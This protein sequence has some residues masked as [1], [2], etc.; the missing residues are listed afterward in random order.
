[1]NVQRRIIT[2]A[3]ENNKIELL[4]PAGSMESLIAAINAG[5][6]AVYAG[7][8]KFGARAFAENFDE[9]TMIKAIKMVHAA[10]KKLYLTV[11]TLLKQSE[12]E[13][14]LASYIRPYYEAGLDA[15]LVQD[16]GVLKFL[17][18]VFP[19]L[20][21]HASTQMSINM[22]EAVS[23]MP[24]TRIVPSRELSLDEI[25][26]LRKST[27]KEI[28]CFAHGALCYSYSGR[29]MFSSL[30]GGRSGNRGMCAGSCRLRYEMVDNG[31]SIADGYL[32]SLK[33]MST[34]SLLPELM[35]AGINS[36]KLEGRMKGPSYAGGVAR[37]Y[38]EAIDSI[39]EKGRPLS[40]EEIRDKERK[41]ADLYNRGGFGTGYYKGIAETFTKRPNHYGVLAGRVT[42]IGEGFVKIKY[43]MDMGAHDVVEIRNKRGV[44]EYEYTLKDEIKKGSEVRANVLRGTHAEI[45]MEVYRTRNENFLKVINDSF[46]KDKIS[47]AILLETKAVTGERLEIKACRKNDDKKDLLYAKVEGDIVE[48]A[49]KQAVSEDRIR[50]AL[51]KTGDTCFFVQEKEDI[52]VKASSDAFLPMSV[53]NDLRRKLLDELYE[54]LANADARLDDKKLIDSNLSHEE[55]VSLISSQKKDEELSDK[56]SE[57]IMQLKEERAR[58]D[59]VNECLKRELLECESGGDS[60]AKRIT[61]FKRSFNSFKM[62]LFVALTKEQFLAAFES[63]GINECGIDITDLDEDEIK[64]LALK[65]HEKGKTFLVQLPAICKVKTYAFIEKEVKNLFSYIDGFIV[66]SNEEVTLLKEIMALVPYAEKKLILG[67]D[68]YTANSFAVDYYHRL[69][70]CFHTVCEELSAE[71]IILKGY[72]DE[73]YLTVYGR[74]PLMQTAGCV[75]KNYE[76]CLLSDKTNKT[77]RECNLASLLPVAQENE[78]AQFIKYNE[79]ICFKI[80]PHCNLKKKGAVCANTI[81]DARLKDLSGNYADVKGTGC[82]GIRFD[83]TDENAKEVRDVL[84]R[85]FNG[86]AAVGNGKK[87]S[88]HFY[89]PVK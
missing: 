35:E 4:A 30:F 85:F 80:K 19:G 50:Q 28:E 47:T 15:V 41:L 37:M 70:Y 39:L 86:N 17:N 5:A 12:I 11:N 60:S 22:A 2:M 18:E 64:E 72:N 27:D 20:E 29:C 8:G 63:P 14:E 16:M 36:L 38:R 76:G 21:L 89:T 44:S 10:G 52:K 58:H 6:D 9:K 26:I 84:N 53:L 83:F 45:G 1:M 62:R 88:G 66:C 48:K 49:S 74:L 7:G 34:I 46:V 42:G 3:I 67:R 59:E 43:E 40:R 71:E 25:K 31:K 51:S 78:K 13:N 33:D 56:I 69:G 55:L 54:V 81:Y 82:A 57:R 65:T 32:L 23:F 75:Y 61:S 77:S 68:L 24:V 73:G 79:G 87:F